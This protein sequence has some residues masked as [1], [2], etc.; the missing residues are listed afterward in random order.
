MLQNRE[1]PYTKY[2]PAWGFTQSRL[3]Q[4]YLFNTQ[5]HPKHLQPR[6]PVASQTHQYEAGQDK[7]IAKKQSTLLQDHLMNSADRQI[8]KSDPHLEDHPRTEVSG[9]D[10][11]IYRPLIIHLEGVSRYPILRRQQRSPWLLTT[12]KSWDDPP[13]ILYVFPSDPHW[14]DQFLPNRSYKNPHHFSHMF[15]TYIKLY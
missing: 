14:F 11:P 6:T 7:Q 10:H 15:Y 13:C 9:Q 4:V 8:L 2:S 12:H 5:K 1:S 3:Q